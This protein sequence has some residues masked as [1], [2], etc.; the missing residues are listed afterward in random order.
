M[1]L[2]ASG[3]LVFAAYFVLSQ[4]FQKQ[5]TAYMLKLM[6]SMVEQGVSTVEYELRVSREQA[7]ALASSFSIP[8]SELQPVLFPTAYTPSN[9]LRMVYVSGDSAIAS[10]G[11]ERDIRGRPDFI[12]AFGGAVSVYGP[13]PNEENEYVICYSAPVYRDNQIAGVLSVEKDGYYFCSRM[14]NI[15]FTDAIE[16][17]IIDADGTDIAASNRSHISWVRRTV[18][19]SGFRF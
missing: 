4:H 11:R 3:A 18:P 7:T 8:A 6:Q 1:F 16:S 19:G 10:D 12:E 5:L 15:R 13:Y 2:I 14:E 17:Y 9:L